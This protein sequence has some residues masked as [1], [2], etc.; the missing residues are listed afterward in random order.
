M[1]CNIP[2][3]PKHI[4][5]FY[6]NYSLQLLQLDPLVPLKQSQECHLLSETKFETVS[7]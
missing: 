1:L 4:Q 6:H 7:R 5:I 3:F 2:P